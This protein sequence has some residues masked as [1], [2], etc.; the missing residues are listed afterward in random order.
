MMLLM[1]ATAWLSLGV[2]RVP[3]GVEVVWIAN[4]IWAGWLLSRRSALWPGYLLVGFLSLLSVCLLVGD[5][6]LSGVILSALNLIEVLLI[7]GFIR[8]GIP[9][10]GNPRSWQA[11]GGTATGITLMACAISGLILVVLRSASGHAEFLSSFL[12]WWSSHVVGMVI[13]GTLTLVVHRK[14]LGMIDVPGKRWDFI[15]CMMLIASVCGGVFYQENYPLL[16]LAYPP[17]LFAVF[18]HRFAGVVVGI[19]LMGLIGSI[20]T[21]LDYG[22]LALVSGSGIIERMILLQL[23]IGAAC[24]MA[25]PVALGMAERAR[26]V[27]RLKDSELR[28]RMLADYSH[29]VVVRMRADGKRLYV[30]PSA[31]EILGW[32]PN[33]LLQADDQF[34]HPD[35]RYVQEQMVAG[36]VASGQSVTS[37][38]RMRHKRGD[39]IWMEVVARR[40]PG[41]AGTTADVILAGRDITERVGAERALEVSRRELESQ[42]SLDSLTGLANRRQFDQRL[43]LAIQRSIRYGSD[44]ALMYIDIDHFKK[45][46]DR[47]GHAV[48]DQVLRIFGQ[49]MKACVRSGDLVARWGGDEFVVLIEDRSSRDAVEAIAK[50]LISAMTEDAV[51]DS[52]KLRVTASIGL[53]YSVGPVPIEVLTGAADAALYEAK[54]AGRDTY[55]LVMA[56][57]SEPIIFPETRV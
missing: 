50:K 13:L 4:G 19:S 16:F 25:F 17:L 29:D 10:V 37:I 48:G 24:V 9:D 5:D 40:I 7:A 33:D 11:L 57:N 34:L 20:A 54:G 27:A 12:T 32:E 55:R 23:F 45:I 51:V 1:G 28:Y 52:R 26:L 21:A 30:S 15:L 22:P 8:H 14:G 36:V 44:L 6:P 3:G 35:D 56:S 53:A 41:E 47:L 43:K 31:K 2:A 49:R 42:A 38:Y 39:Y 18:R 46:N